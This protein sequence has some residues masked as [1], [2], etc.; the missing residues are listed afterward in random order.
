MIEV[1]S[2]E[3]WRMD[4]RLNKLQ[5]THNVEYIASHLSES[6]GTLVLVVKTTPITHVGSDS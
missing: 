2:T 6:G 3:P 4:A 5:E 1:L